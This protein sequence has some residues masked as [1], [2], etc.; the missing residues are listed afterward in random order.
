MNVDKREH[1][2]SSKK[3]SKKIYDIFVGD[4]FTEFSIDTKT[5]KESNVPPI[6][7]CIL[8]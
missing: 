5:E 3:Q 4:I 8:L 6:G 1:Y 7:N 2:L